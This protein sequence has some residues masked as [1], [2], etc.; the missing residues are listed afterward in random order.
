[1]SR[2]KETS[3][4]GVGVQYEFTTSKG[5]RMGVVHH[6]SGRREMFLCSPDDPDSAAL[7]VGLDDEDAF[8]LG[9]ALD[10][11]QIVESVSPAKYEVEGLVFEWIPITEESPASGKT[12]GDMRLRTLTGSSVV[13]V[14]RQGGSTP[15]PGPEFGLIAGDTLVVAGT[16][17]GIDAVIDLVDGR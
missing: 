16:P 17:D 8:A 13:A 3:L 14:L 4:P 11:L 15:A 1:M 5:R 10:V 7:T 6:H 2:I 9:E 12:I